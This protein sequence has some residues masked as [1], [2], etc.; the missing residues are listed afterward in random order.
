M[1]EVVCALNLEYI[2]RE[3]DG[4]QTGQ[5]AMTLVLPSRHGWRH[6]QLSN[7]QGTPPIDTRCKQAA[8]LL[9]GSSSTRCRSKQ[10]TRYEASDKNAYDAPP[11]LSVGSSLYTLAVCVA[12]SVAEVLVP[13]LGLLY[14]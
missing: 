3:L 9:A 12:R 2:Q 5:T 13:P 10:I 4:G 1:V 14:C 8:V 6:G 11:A 7:P